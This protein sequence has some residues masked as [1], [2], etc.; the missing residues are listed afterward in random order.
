M[1]LAKTDVAK[2]ALHD[3]LAEDAKSA[4]GGNVLVSKSEGK[5]LD[6]ANRRAELALRQEGGK[7]TR[8]RAEQIADRAS[9]DAT[10]VWDQFNVRGSHILS[11]AEVKA[12]GAADPAL[13]GVT[14]QAYLRARGLDNPNKAVRTFFETFDF[15]QRDTL[16][17][18]RRIDARVGQPGRA[19]VP[20]AVLGAFDYYS[21][22]ETADWATVRLH[23][24]R[25]AGKPIY[26]VATSTDGDEGYLEVYK[27]SGE[28]MFSARL[29]GG[30]LWAHDSFFGQARL[31]SSLLGL[32]NARWDEGLS[33]APERLAAGQVP[34]EWPGDVKIGAGQIHHDGGLLHHIELPAGQQLT[35][36]QQKAM[37]AAVA[38]LW[39]NTFSPR[40][41]PRANDA[42]TL[43]ARGQGEMFIGEFTR[44]DDGKTY[45]VADWRDIDDASAVFYF[46][47]TKDDLHLA[48]QQYDG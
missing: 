11:K 27:K 1:K 26:A 29:Q 22:A 18:G 15:T 16:P 8:V 33:E 24:A 38:L 32:D 44:P 6:P 23:E 36:P 48:I 40:L 41:D 31:S 43:G 42:L 47:Q 12:I 2:T 28:P 17:R 7:G 45:L 34:R 37:H 30:Q 4:A 35:G 10:K 13:A 46:T 21:R 25:V 5:Q 14:Q 39:D 20:K 3:L 9:T 19:N